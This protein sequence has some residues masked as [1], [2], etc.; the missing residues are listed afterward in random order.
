MGGAVIDPHSFC[1][2]T[3]DIPHSFVVA[4]SRKEQ[5]RDEDVGALY[6]EAFRMESSFRMVRWKNSSV[7]LSCK[8]YLR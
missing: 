2:T 7:S 6:V 3:Q 1:H 8:P 4:I 5:G